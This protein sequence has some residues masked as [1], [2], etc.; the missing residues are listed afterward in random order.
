MINLY[1]VVYKASAKS[2]STQRGIRCA[3][4]ASCPALTAA[5]I[6]DG[7][8]VVSVRLIGEMVGPWCQIGGA[9]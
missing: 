5:L 1:E 3:E 9:A 7:A 8:V 6:E 4:H 2:R